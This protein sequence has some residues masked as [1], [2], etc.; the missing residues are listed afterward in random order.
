M[1]NSTH[2]SSAQDVIGLSRVAKKMVTAI[3]RIIKKN[4]TRKH[5]VLLYAGMSGIAAATAIS[6]ELYRQKIKHSMI[7]VRK[8][9]ERSHGQ[10]V[11]HNLT[12]KTIEKNGFICFIDDFIDS[13]TTYGRCIAQARVRF[14]FMKQFRAEDYKVETEIHELLTQNFS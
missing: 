5:P 14:T 3:K 11:E 7:Y 1:N 6:L 9:G 4:D 10:K 8:K 12:I 13:G 2:Y